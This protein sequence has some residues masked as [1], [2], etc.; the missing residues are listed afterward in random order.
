MHET[1]GD[2]KWNEDNIKEQPQE[3]SAQDMGPPIFITLARIYDLIAVLAIN[4]DPAAAGQ[5]L[6][7]HEMGLLK[8]ALPS[9]AMPG[10]DEEDDIR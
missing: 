8:G 4:A 9:L 10:E 1:S 3:W 6:A 5:V 2:N 7:L